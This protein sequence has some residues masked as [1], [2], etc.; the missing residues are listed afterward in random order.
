MAATRR[1]QSVASRIGFSST[2]KRAKV[3][4][5]PDLQLR[6][7]IRYNN[8]PL[9]GFPR[10]R[11]GNEGIFDVGIEIPIFNRNQGTVAAAEADAERARLEIDR[12]RLELRHRLAAVF[13][14]YSDAASAAARYRE[15][16]L[17]QARQAFEMYTGNFRNMAVAYPLV[18]STQRSLI[19]LEEDYIGQLM[20]AWRAAAEIE[21]LLTME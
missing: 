2:V 14:E 16:M 13:R 12:E 15:D 20:T 10:R 5:I 3:E 8:E 19:Q 7:G 17:P 6:G 9:E 4:R 11:V 1:T 21:G 18:L